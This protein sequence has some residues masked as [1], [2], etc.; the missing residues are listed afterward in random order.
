[1]WARFLLLL[2]CFTC[3]FW[4]ITFLLQWKTNT[5]S[6]KIWTG[7]VF[8]MGISTFIW[9][10]YMGGIQDHALFYKVEVLEIFT[11]LLFFPLLYFAF[12]SLT[13]EEPFNW[14]DYL[15]LL[16][17][18]M[19]AISLMTMYA[20]M[21][22]EQVVV[23]M[24]KLVENKGDITAF[25]AP[26]FQFHHFVSV[27]LYKILIFVQIFF[28]LVLTTIRL[29]RYRHRL[30]DY[31]S[32][33]DDNSMRHQYALLA[34][35]YVVLL[36]ALFT[37]RGDFYYNGDAWFVQFT[38]FLWAAALYFM[39]YHL[40]RLEYTADNLASDLVEADWAEGNGECVDA[41]EQYNVIK[42]L[43]PLFNQIID[44]EQ[45]FLQNN[46]HLDDVAR[47]MRTNRT[48][49]S[50][51]INE[52]FQCNFSDFINMKRI[53]YAQELMRTNPDMS[54]EQIAIQSGFSHPSSF[55]RTFKRQTGV[56]FRDWQRENLF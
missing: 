13:S 30:D 1:M 9:G 53:E 16:P 20:Y 28:L 29:V 52:E 38:M 54:Q 15:W 56:T 42:N 2:P 24:T 44:E 47:V 22:E 8:V 18:P 39:C 48:Y 3:L 4:S 40:S 37:C 14:K 51:L 49:I 45:V 19:I 11:T 7:T 26:V 32:T 27:S 10:Y 12:K 33:L 6:R 43:L 23:Y 50:R 21:G 31:F 5:R 17:A 46:L 55:S 25:T 35:L 41:N 34:G 36:L